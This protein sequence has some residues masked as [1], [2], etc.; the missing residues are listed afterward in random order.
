MGLTLTINDT[1]SATKLHVTNG[2]KTIFKKSG[3]SIKSL[4][5]FVLEGTK[6]ETTKQSIMELQHSYMFMVGSKTT[7]EIKGD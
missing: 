2:S 6:K 1:G 7:V 4:L 3:K 5:K